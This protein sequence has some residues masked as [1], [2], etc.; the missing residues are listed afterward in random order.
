M[1]C[2]F[3]EMKSTILILL[4]VFFLSADGYPQIRRVEQEEYLHVPGPGVVKVKDVVI[5]KDERFHSAFPSVIRLPAGE[6]CVAFRRAPDRK[7]FGEPK[8]PD[9][10]NLLTYCVKSE[11]N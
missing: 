9:T 11:I 6:L 8:L 10:Q 7:I 2:N 5:Y 4:L 1:H 3:Q